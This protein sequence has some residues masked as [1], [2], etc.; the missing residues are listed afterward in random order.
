V[1]Q[2]RLGE[3]LGDGPQQKRRRVEQESDDDDSEP[4]PSS[5][6]ER[7]PQ[8]NGDIEEG[9]DSEG[10][11]WTLGGLR[12]DDEDS[13]LDSDDA[14]GESDEE[15]FAGYSFRGSSSKK[16]K[17]RRSGKSASK[18][19][20]GNR[21]IDL[22]EQSE[23]DDDEEEG[24]D[25]ATMLDDDDDES[26]SDAPPGLVDDDTSSEEDEGDVVSDS[27]SALDGGTEKMEEERIARMR[28]RV[29]ALDPAPTIAAKAKAPTTLTLEALLGEADQSTKK[30]IAKS[31]K[32]I[33]SHVFIV[34]VR[35]LVCIDSSLDN[36]EDIGTL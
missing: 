24:V 10:N 15:R 11:E 33:T 19:E 25:L 14:F 2:N 27:G 28:D 22:D 35:T 17:S 31:S 21:D 8:S 16:G 26:V 3:F 32:G 34:F 18:V 13:D 30:E 6:R 29:D 23:D 5:T 36:S 20:D 1:R 7:R 4:Q 12:E 9:S